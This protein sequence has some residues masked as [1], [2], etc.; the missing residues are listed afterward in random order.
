LGEVHEPSQYLSTYLFNDTI[1][2]DAGCLGHYGTFADQVRVRNVFL[3]HSHIDHIGSLPIFVDNVYQGGLDCVTVHASREVIDCLKR[4]VFNDRVWPDFIRLST[5]E[6]P[7]F[8]LSILEAYRPVEVDG[9]RFTPVPVDHVVPTFGFVIESPTSAVVV[10]SD[11]G[12]TTEL[13]ERANA[14]PNLKAVFLEA[15]FPEAL[16]P[17]AQ[18]SKHLTPKQFAQEVEKLSCR[19]AVIAVH[20]KSRYFKELVSE[21]QALNISRLEI[22]RFDRA[23]VF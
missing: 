3:T 20:L 16:A 9:L 6:A 13:W 1:A 14:T 22:G 11:T 5:P 19:P 10:A 7:F 23:Y 8:K 4:D 21:L 15:S 17:L 18:V 12:P 2:V